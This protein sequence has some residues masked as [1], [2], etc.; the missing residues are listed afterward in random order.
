MCFG[1]M[2]KDCPIAVTNGA[3]GVLSVMTTWYGPFATALLTSGTS[4][5]GS[6][7][8]YLRM[9]S[10]E[11]T[12][13]ADVNGL[14]SDHFTPCRRLNVY[15]SPPL[16]TCQDVARSGTGTSALFRYTSE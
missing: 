7:G 15:V 11:Y 2:E 3:N 4:A 12:T 5:A 13:S 14:P 9:S 8:L 10:I 16:E 1:R 6:Y